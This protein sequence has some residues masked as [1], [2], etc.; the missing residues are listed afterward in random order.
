MTG[1]LVAY[2]VAAYEHVT[3]HSLSAFVWVTLAAAL[4]MVGAFRAWNEEFNK[5][6]LADNPEILIEYEKRPMQIAAPLLIMKN[7][8]GGNAYRLKIRDITNGS[9]LA[10]FNE[11]SYLEE[12]Q[13]CEATATFNNFRVPT[14]FF[15]DNFAAFLRTAGGDPGAM[16]AIEYSLAAREIKVVVDYFSISDMRFTAEFEIRS[17]YAWEEAHTVPVRRY[18]NP[19]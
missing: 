7:L 6:M 1:G 15:P 10:V 4:F 2:S 17:T 13:I 16:E 19:G 5:A 3:G 11:V 12:K 9:A 14:P 8:G 18:F